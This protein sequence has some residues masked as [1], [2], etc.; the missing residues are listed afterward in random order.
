MPSFV[1]VAKDIYLIYRDTVYSPSVGKALAKALCAHF[2][3]SNVED[4]GSGSMEKI[5]SRINITEVKYH[6]SVRQ[7]KRNKFSFSGCFFF[8]NFNEYFAEKFQV[9]VPRSPHNRAT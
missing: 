8:R 9:F 2:N 5:C 1:T 4:L 3:I 6:F 7:Q